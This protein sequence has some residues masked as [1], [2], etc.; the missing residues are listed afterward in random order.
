MFRC[1]LSHLR[2]TC[3]MCRGTEEYSSRRDEES[4]DHKLS[5][6]F[7]LAFNFVPGG[8]GD[9]YQS[10]VIYR[11]TLYQ[12]K[13]APSVQSASPT[14]GHC[15]E[16]TVAAI[17]RRLLALTSGSAEQSGVEVAENFRGP[18]FAIV[19]TVP[20]P[21]PGFRLH[22]FPASGF[23]GALSFVFLGSFLLPGFGVVAFGF[24]AF[25]CPRCK[26]EYDR[27]E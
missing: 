25:P 2:G 21:F 27:L 9:T 4:R 10:L 17:V 23:L 3:T 12:L 16:V 22:V 14:V 18:F 26:N 11:V 8:L 15:L 7:L 6:R 5:V 1:P 19:A 24:M 13:A 20:F